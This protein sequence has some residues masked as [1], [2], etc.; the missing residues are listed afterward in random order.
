MTKGRHL[1]AALFHVLRRA[2]S[3]FAATG[4]IFQIDPM[5]LGKF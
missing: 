1:M 5:G 3:T 2:K 4:N